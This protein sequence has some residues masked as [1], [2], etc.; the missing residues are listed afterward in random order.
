M[1]SAVEQR[2]QGDEATLYDRSLY[3]LL[4][5]KLPGEY[6]KGDRLDTQRICD[7]TGNARFTVYRW[8]NEGNLSK[9]AMKSLL[10]LSNNTSGK[11]KGALTREDLLPFFL[12]L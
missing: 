8:L 5:A 10:E 11:K 4:L 3:K 6:V 9:K 1:D 7:A 12:G 2:R